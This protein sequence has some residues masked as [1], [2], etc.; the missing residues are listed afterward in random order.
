[1]TENPVPPGSPD[2]PSTEKW[3]GTAGGP[4][5]PDGGPQYPYGYPPG[6]YA[7]GGAYPG[8]P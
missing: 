6:P 5:P 3:P 4:L 7:P 1:M 8:G 2:F